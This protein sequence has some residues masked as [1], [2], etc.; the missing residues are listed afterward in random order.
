MAQSK[1]V[2][3]PFQM[4]VSWCF[5]R[6]HIHFCW[7]ELRVALWKSAVVTAGSL[8]GPLCI[9]A[10]AG[11]GF[12]LSI[13]STTLAI[14]LALTG[15]LAAALAVH[16]PVLLELAKGREII[17]PKLFGSAREPWRPGS[18]GSRLNDAVIAACVARSGADEPG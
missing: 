9:L 13:Q 1:L 10:L 15:W 14:L 2:T 11:S 6:R 12:N 8:A 5:V 18:R 3:L 17:R 4:V 7:S 16:H